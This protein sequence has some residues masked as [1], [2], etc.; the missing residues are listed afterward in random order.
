MPAKYLLPNQH[1]PL[2]LIYG[3]ADCCLC[4]AERELKRI[5]HMSESGWRLLMEKMRDVAH[6]NVVLARKNR[7]IKRQKKALKR[8]NDQIHSRTGQ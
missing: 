8:F 2:H 6:L 1:T 4:K 5:D 3:Q 7:Q